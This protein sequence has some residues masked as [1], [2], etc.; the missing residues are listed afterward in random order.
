MSVKQPVRIYIIISTSPF[1]NWCTL[2]FLNTP[3]DKFGLQ[4]R[5]H[6]C[7]GVHSVEDEV[8]TDKSASEAGETSETKEEDLDE[9][10]GESS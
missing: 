10:L 5:I 6:L 1:T 8:N 7:S 2:A 3:R 4:A 9:R